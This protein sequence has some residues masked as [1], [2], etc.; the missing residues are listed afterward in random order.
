MAHRKTESILQQTLKTTNRE[1]LLNRITNR[2]RQSL[3]LQEILD[4]TVREIRSFLGMDRVKIYRFLADGSGE[5][6][7]ESIYRNRLPALRGLRFPAS[8]IPLQAREMFVK[9]R[10][11]VIV[12][13]ASGRKILQGLDSP[14]TGE[15]LIVED[16]RYA[17][18]DPCHIDY[19][20]TMGVNSSLVVPILYQNQLWGLLA[21]HHS[22]PRTYNEEDLRI[23]QLLVDQV[24]IAIAQ[25]DLL[26]RTRQQADS[27]AKIN[28]ISY[29]LHSP[30]NQAE[31]RQTI[32]E[33]V[34]T[35]LQGCGGRLYT[36]A[37][38][39]GNPPQI[40][41]CGE[42]PHSN[43]EIEESSFWQSILI[44]NPVYPTDSAME[45]H[46]FD[47][48]GSLTSIPTTGRNGGK[49][50]EYFTAY[51]N[52]IPNLYLVPDIYQ[53][54][55]IKAI[56]PS[57]HG[58]SIRSMLIVP[59][60]YQH[61]C[62]G[63][64]TLFR[65]EIETT[66]LWAGH[67]NPDE[68]NLRPRESFDA[69][70]ET[71]RGQA[72]PWTLE[73]IRLAA[74]IG[75]HLYMAVMQKRVEETIRHQASHDLLTGLPNRVL[76]SDRLTLALAKTHRY[77]E[78]LAVIFLDLDGFKTINDTLGHAVGDQLLKHVARRLK[79]CLREEDTVA[80]W[81]GD[82]FTILLNFV[83]SVEDV[84]RI[85]QRIL[86]SLSTPFQ[87]EAD[88]THQVTSLHIK[89][90]LGIAL[91]PYDGEDTETLLK[92]ADAAMY[93]A[94]RQ[95]RNN[96]QMYTPSI[97]TKVREK[98]VLEN[99][100][101]KALDREEF[102]LYY[103]PQMDI[104]TGKIISMEALIRWQ[105]RDLGLISPDV[106]IPLAEE[107]G[108]ICPIGEWVLRTAC[109]Q[110][111]AWQLAGL[112]PL[113]IAVNLSARQFQ[114]S[115]LA[116]TVAGILK[117]TGLDPQ[118][119]E[120]EIT[121]SIAIQDINFTID[122]LQEFQGMGIA[123]AMDDF[124]TGYSS[125]SSLK[126]IPIDKLKIDR[127]FIRDLVTDPHDAAIIEAVVA[128]GQGLNLKVV[129]EGVE[130]PEQLQ[131]LQSVHCDAIQGYLFS[132]PLPAEAMTQFCLHRKWA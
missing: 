6:I 87:F 117:E 37:D 101:Y 35:A 60:R 29:L 63:C 1:S 5:V 64:L 10:Q 92:H 13:V 65:P 79:D 28:Q 68:R 97:S 21:C 44:S 119:L 129:A 99:K 124:G 19:L 7:S 93:L 57:F 100:L 104:A 48:R 23:V 115:N 130:T 98:L 58:T 4:T 27:E 16:I 131:F 30:L 61:Q 45:I 39:I 14:L 8:D 56:A 53:E 40:Y 110:N 77:G 83:N 78:I 18:V 38:L 50:S 36:I 132:K 113:Q 9:V 109:A 120:L 107:N 47:F 111:R 54:P 22:K 52:I 85:A 125:L 116:A 43:L 86:N 62:V 121:E 31:I 49:S 3:E 96:Y 84:G 80:R 126:H 95:G 105:C 108:L 32:L 46:N 73:E 67:Q 66:T 69:W 81:G 72:K 24:S 55:A 89:A 20:T 90:S 51:Q 15:N 59:L 91:A 94:K 11:R 33:E 123:I 118:Y 70:Q 2:I 88:T 34:V 122:L 112:P 106:F 82:E 74:A 42:Q 17:P 102:L 127:T 12:D 75:L 25:A 41:T 103:Q 26:A 76:F 128:L 114:Q 71:I